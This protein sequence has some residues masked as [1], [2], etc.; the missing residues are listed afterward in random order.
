MRNMLFALA[1]LSLAASAP[2]K[3][4]P[5]DQI[6]VAAVVRATLAPYANA[7]IV[8]PDQFTAPRWGRQT[9]QLIKDWQ[10]APNS[11]GDV[12]PLADGDWLCQCQ[13]WDA[14]AFRINTIRSTGS[15]PG[16]IIADVRYSISRSAQRRLKFV[17]IREA[18]QWRIDDLVFPDQ[19]D[20]LKAQL[21]SETAAR[22]RE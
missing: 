18:G 12:S 11:S 5:Q 19:R 1:S 8:A 15:A 3:T 21:R 9:R 17:M 16:R 2:A 20:S 4:A 13:D 22:R 10:T 14:K 6:A 7:K